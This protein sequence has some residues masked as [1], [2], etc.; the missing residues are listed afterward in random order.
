[1]N[2]YIESWDYAFGGATLPYAYNN[3]SPYV[4]SGFAHFP[5]NSFVNKDFNG[6]YSFQS[7]NY[8]GNYAITFTLD[9]SAAGSDAV[10]TILRY[11]GGSPFH[12][13]VRTNTGV[14]L[15]WNE[16]SSGPYTGSG[17]GS[18]PDGDFNG[19]A[20][21]ELGVYTV[22][23]VLKPNGDGTSNIAMRVTS[24]S[25]AHYMSGWV[26]CSDP[27]EH[28]QIGSN[29]Q[30]TGEWIIGPLSVNDDLTVEE[31]ELLRTTGALTPK[32]A[33][34]T[35]N[36][37]NGS[38]DFSVD[39]ELA[40][41]TPDSTVYYTT[42]GSA[43]T[44]SSSVYSTAIHLTANTT[45]RAFATAA[46]V[47][48]SAIASANY[49]I[50]TNPICVKPVIAVIG[51]GATRDVTITCATPSATIY[52]TLDGSNPSSSS[53]LYTGS[54]QVDE[55]ATIKAVATKTLY[56]R[57]PYAA[58]SALIKFGNAVI[59]GRAYLTVVMPDGKEWLDENFA[60]DAVGYDYG[61][62]PSNSVEYGRLYSASDLATIVALLTSGWHLPAEIDSIALVAAIGGSSALKLKSPGTTYWTTANGTNNYGFDARGSGWYNGSS[63]LDLTLGFYIWLDLSSGSYNKIFGF[64]DS[65]TI[66]GNGGAGANDRYSVRLVR[67]KCVNPEIGRLSGSY[68]STSIDVKITCPDENAKFFYTTNGDDP[69]ES[70]TP[71][72]GPINISSSLTL[73]VIATNGVPSDV[74]SATYVLNA[75]ISQ[76]R[77]LLVPWSNADDLW[78]TRGAVTF[79]AGALSADAANGHTSWLPAYGTPVQRDATNEVNFS[80][81]IACY[82]YDIELAANSTLVFGLNENKTYLSFPE[83]TFEFYRESDAAVRFV[84][85]RGTLAGFDGTLMVGSRFKLRLALN[86][87]SLNYL[88]DYSY[89][90][91]NTSPVRLSVVTQDGTVVADSDWQTCAWFMPNYVQD[92]YFYRHPYYG[93]PAFALKRGQ[94][95]MHP[96]RVVST[97]TQS[98]CS[99]FITTGSTTVAPVPS[100]PQF[101]VTKLHDGLNRVIITPASYD[102]SMI[103]TVDEGYFTA[104]AFDIVRNKRAIFMAPGELFVKVVAGQCVF[105]AISASR[106]RST[107]GFSAGERRSYAHVSAIATQA[108]GDSLV[109]IPE[110]TPRRD[111]LVPGYSTPVNVYCADADATIRYTIDGSEPTALSPVWA[112]TMQVREPLWLRVKTFKGSDSSPTQNGLYAFRGEPMQLLPSTADTSLWVGT[113]A[114]FAAGVITIDDPNGSGVVLRDDIAIN[115]T[116]LDVSCLRFRA[117]GPFRMRIPGVNGVHL[118]WVGD[119]IGLVTD[120]GEEPGTDFIAQSYADVSVAFSD[121]IVAYYSEIPAVM[122]YAMIR[123]NGSST[124]VTVALTKP[125]LEAANKLGF[126]SEGLSSYVISNLEIIRFGSKTFELQDKSAWTSLLSTSSYPLARSEKPVFDAYADN[127]IAGQP[128]VAT[129]STSMT[130]DYSYMENSDPSHSTYSSPPTL[131][132]TGSDNGYALVAAMNLETGKLPRVAWHAF[133]SARPFECSVS[134]WDR[135]HSWT[136]HYIVSSGYGVSSI[137]LVEQP[138]QLTNERWRLGR[139]WATTKLINPVDMAGNAW[140]SFEARSLYNDSYVEEHRPEYDIVV[141]FDTPL[142]LAMPVLSSRPLKGIDAGRITNATSSMFEI[143]K[144]I[145]LCNLETFETAH[146][147]HVA[148]TAGNHSNNFANWRCGRKIVA[149]VLYVRVAAVHDW[150]FKPFYDSGWINCGAASTQPRPRIIIRTRTLD[151][152]WFP[153]HLVNCFYGHDNLQEAELE[154]L[155]DYGALSVPDAPVLTAANTLNSD[156][157]VDVTLT[158]TGSS[159]VLV[160]IGDQEPQVRVDSW[161]NSSMSKKYYRR[162]AW[163]YANSGD[164]NSKQDDDFFTSDGA[165]FQVPALSKIRA[166]ALAA[167]YTRLIPISGNNNQFTWYAKRSAFGSLEVKRPASDLISI[168][169]AEPL[170]AVIRCTPPSNMFT[171]EYS[172]D[173]WSIAMAHSYKLVFDDGFEFE[174]QAWTYSGY[175]RPNDLTRQLAPGQH[176]VKLVRYKTT[177][178]FGNYVLGESDRLLFT[179]SESLSL[180]TATPSSVVAGAT[181]VFSA[182]GGGSSFSW[183]FSDGSTATGAIVNKTFE[184]PGRY[185]WRV[186]ADDGK[187]QCQSSG[188]FVVTFTTSTLPENMTSTEELRIS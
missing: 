72:T 153:F 27:T 168:S 70:S 77:E 3:G 106:E 82:E 160:C 55:S 33:T 173:D 164:G 91:S 11:G 50:V 36:P 101:S 38:Y 83:R 150:Q 145:R 165:T 178:V 111:E 118:A 113:N 15:G 54:F 171:L 64:S 159:R 115:T 87:H 81:F 35:F 10:F 151:G 41:A 102:D 34:P 96:F 90:V 183:F 104:S 21:D 26:P 162:R 76:T 135:V 97:C 46:G 134:T 84:V 48:D 1:M 109:A 127:N 61:D 99:E 9:T 12:A 42:D 18:T 131:I 139:R 179:V 182:A 188:S 63:Y 125:T 73:K 152:S 107:S 8:V 140:F 75:T 79:N 187:E 121:Y 57:S 71:Y 148:S 124:S 114:T 49:V 5:V 85:R 24:P 93:A 86:G 154:E 126:T 167:P 100:A 30:G 156:G 47:D 60:Y 74:V 22:A 175:E 184:K 133:N 43:P 110:I 105:R 44:S 137:E 51:S 136:N 78:V 161:D 147:A 169:T 149:G 94:V 130:C 14:W 13:I 172:S 176:W 69:T 138:S 180:Q 98:Q 186:V 80:E 132:P 53:T 45:V 92:A 32:C 170:T 177:G 155:F 158:A 163:Y 103:I 144:I 67:E 185:S 52:Y 88:S 68:D 7:F 40:C 31:A 4:Q 37:G 29:V 95:T 17:Q 16:Y 116:H 66:A 122:R 39:V 19:T 123:V 2:A 58:W 166:I 142:N 119:K 120:T 174:L 157:T 129:N 181:A 62:T 146:G 56:R 28:N 23:Y 117:S 20:I 141:G 6:Y 25:G 112:G 128:V 65:A 143:A 89:Y 108:V 59:F